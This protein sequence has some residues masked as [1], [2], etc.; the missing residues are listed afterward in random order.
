MGWITV[1]YHFISSVV[2]CAVDHSAQ[3]AAV[4]TD[5]AKCMA[6]KFFLS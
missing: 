5:F 4:A 6:S 2:N 1:G 3:I